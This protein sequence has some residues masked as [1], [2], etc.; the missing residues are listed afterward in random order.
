MSLPPPPRS[1]SPSRSRP[2]PLS[3]PPAVDDLGEGPPIRLANRGER[4]I[5]G[6]SH[7]EQKSPPVGVRHP[8]QRPRPLLSPPQGMPRSDAR[9]ARHDH[10]SHRALPR[11]A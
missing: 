9:I 1:P 5:G 4:T 11:L 3:P 10:H 2:P 7:A 6:I 8:Q